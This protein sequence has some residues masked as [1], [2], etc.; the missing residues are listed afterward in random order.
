MWKFQDKDSFAMCDFE[1]A[2]QI[3]NGTKSPVTYTVTETSFFSS[4]VG[5][6]CVYGQKLMVTVIPT[7]MLESIYQETSLSSSSNEINIVWNAGFSDSLARSISIE[8]ESVLRFSWRNG[9]YNVWKFQDKESF[10][11]CDFESAIQ[12]P[13]GGKSPVTY[14]VTKT[15]FFACQIG[16]NCVYGQKLMVTVG[17]TFIPELQLMISMSSETPTELRSFQLSI[18]SS[19]NQ[20]TSLTTGSTFTPTQN[21]TVNPMQDPTSFPLFSTAQS[22]NPS[23]TPSLLTHVIVSIFII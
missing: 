16:S 2:T 5:S 20:S 21:P 18:K 14:T 4:K 9:L 3:I 23:S 8:K 10:D 22:L 11:T 6:N 17:S 19:I 7:P 15:S 13:G 1:S 12:I